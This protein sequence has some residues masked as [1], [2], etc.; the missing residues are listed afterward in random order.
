MIT[1]LCF[2]TNWL[3][4]GYELTPSRPQMLNAQPL[5]FLTYLS[6]IGRHLAL[7]GT[8]PL[9]SAITSGLQNSLHYSFSCQCY[10]DPLTPSFADMAIS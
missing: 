3:I 2:C 1:P 10:L 6:C 9:P 7:G 8:L 5:L 4:D